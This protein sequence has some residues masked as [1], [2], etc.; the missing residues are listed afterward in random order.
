M[1]S[2]ETRLQREGKGKEEKRIKGELEQKKRRRT[3]H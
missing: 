2:E 3:K 1:A